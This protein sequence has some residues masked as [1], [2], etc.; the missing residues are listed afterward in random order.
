MAT[1]VLECE[2][3][4]TILLD[5]EG[6]NAIGTSKTMAMSLLTVTTLLSSYL[7][8]NSKKVPQKVDEKTM[9]CF[10]QLCRSLLAQKGSP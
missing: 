3:F 10:T 7:I 8:Y 6:I 5:T 2:E 4:V 1:T 9:R